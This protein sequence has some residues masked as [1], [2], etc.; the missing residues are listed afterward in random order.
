MK[1]IS[2][3]F[4][5]P[6]NTL[7]EIFY[8]IIALVFLLCGVKALKDK[9]CKERY[10]TFAFWAVLAATFAIGPFFPNWVTGVCICVMAVLSGL[11]KIKVT[12]SDKPS[13]E[14][15]AE[16]AA[17]YGYKVFIPILILAFGA[18]IVATATSVGAANAVGIAGVIATVVTLLICKAPAKYVVTDSTRIMDEI[19]AIGIFPQLLS[20]LG[21]LFTAAGV[22]DVI[23][24]GVAHIIPEGNHFI[25]V[26]VLCLAMYVFTV[27][28][29]NGFAALSVMLIGIGIP[30]LIE[31]GA[32]VEIIGAIGAS[33]AM[34]GTLC[35]PM[36]ANFNVMPAALLQ[37]K[38]CKW[39]IVKAQFPVA[40]ALL[41][42]H[43]LLIYFLAWRV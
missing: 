16:F 7:G 18:V 5:S 27:F 12:K 22:G 28:M 21:A 39:G 25:A 42:V 38:D 34:C 40:I 30:F 4:S 8:W 19:G 32:S 29:G 11:K 35:T 43:I 26:V 36:G 41:I 2:E 9:E 10:F 20:A 14:K 15:A 17:K 23:S 3:V 6:V 1:S 37:M 24:G 33:A 31:Q 13:M